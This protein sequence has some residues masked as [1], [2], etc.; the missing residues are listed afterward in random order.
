MKEGTI[1]CTCFGVTDKE[2]ETAVRDN[3]LTTVEEVTNFTKGR[4]RLRR[5]P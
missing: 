5:M 2:I 3:N 4:R 1:V